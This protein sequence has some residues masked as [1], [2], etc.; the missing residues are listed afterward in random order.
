MTSGINVY[1]SGHFSGVP[2]FP[3][4]GLLDYEAPNNTT[5]PSQA[6]RFAQGKPIQE[7]PSCSARSKA[8]SRYFPQLACLLSDAIIVVSSG[9]YVVVVFFNYYYSYFNNF[10]FYFYFLTKKKVFNLIQ[11]FQSFV[12]LHQQTFLILKMD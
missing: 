2:T 7:L 6:V 9:Q 5:L 1:Y 8:V 3:L 4:I 10:Y 12:R 11:H